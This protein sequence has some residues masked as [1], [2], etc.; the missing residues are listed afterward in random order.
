MTASTEEI[1][2]ANPFRNSP[3]CAKELTLEVKDGSSDTNRQIA[4]SNVFNV[5]HMYKRA[6]PRPGNDQ[7]QRYE[8]TGC[9]VDCSRF[10]RKCWIIDQ[11][12]PTGWYVDLECTLDP[13]GRVDLRS[14]RKLIVTEHS[15]D[16]MQCGIERIMN[17]ECGSRRCAA[18]R[19]Y[20]VFLAHSVRDVQ[21]VGHCVCLFDAR[22]AEKKKEL[23]ETRLQRRSEPEFLPGA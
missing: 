18:L 4:L 7:V 2:V 11:E 5:E 19:E 1:F 14:N 13:V 20:V 16:P 23:G 3:Q 8:N 9:T 21:L 22:I 6:T 17:N 10:E 12:N 15:T